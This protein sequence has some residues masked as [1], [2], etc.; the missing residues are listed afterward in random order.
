MTA[1]Q[2]IPPARAWLYLWQQPEPRYR[3]MV[4]DGPLPADRM[5]RFE[6]QPGAIW[7]Q[8]EDWA[9]AWEL[10]HGIGQSPGWHDDAAAWV[11]INRIDL[12]AGRRAEVEAACRERAALVRHCQDW[13]EALTVLGKAGL[14]VT[15]TGRV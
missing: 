14:C 13:R 2:M 8:V 9:D 11:E 4:T 1:P 7:R 5:A 12:M 15:L 10:Y 3:V 6:K